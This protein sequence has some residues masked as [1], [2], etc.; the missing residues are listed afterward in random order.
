MAE[1]PGTGIALHFIEKPP[2]GHAPIFYG[3]DEGSLRLGSVNAG[4]SEALYVG[5]GGINGGFAR[6][7]GRTQRIDAYAARHTA[8]IEAAKDGEA[9]ERY[10]D[11][12]PT[13]FSFAL[14]S[15]IDGSYEGV[16]FVDVFAPDRCPAGNPK[17]AAML[18][19][20]PPNGMN[21][22]DE[23]EFL[24]AIGKTGQNIATAVARY[25]AI[26]PRETQPVIDALRLCLYSSGIYNRHGVSADRIALAIYDGVASGLTT[27][28][29]LKELQ[30]PVSDDPGDPLFA[31]VKA[32]YG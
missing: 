22:P 8:L 30:M 6:Q 18:Y 17:N 16:C 23:T 2:G 4:N 11:D 1:I 14:V 13:A 21:H 10:E 20:A 19:A 25:N 31:A 28:S 29:G 26:A 3:G 9:F 15:R 24:A 27:D 12:D 5:G 7:L 32:K